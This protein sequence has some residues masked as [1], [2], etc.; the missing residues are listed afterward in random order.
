MTKQKFENALD[1]MDALNANDPNPIQIDGHDQPAALYYARQMTKTL[2]NL[3]PGA[4]NALKLAARAQHIERW[5]V[6]RDNY[7]KGRAGYHRWRNDLKERHAKSAS[8]I[9]RNCGFDEELTTRV[10]GLIA[11]K[12]LKTD[13]ETK[14]LEDVAC[15]VFFK[16][17]A[18]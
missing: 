17:Y 11:K 6:P 2:E 18:A 16:Y 4:S 13:P 7:P 5:K 8:Q 3:Y 1:A 15:I 9:L 14:A 10:A 12:N